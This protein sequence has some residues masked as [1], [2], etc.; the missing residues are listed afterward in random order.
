M[1][2][3]VRHCDAEDIERIIE[4]KCNTP[5]ESFFFRHTL[6][7]QKL[8]GLKWQRL[9]TYVARNDHLRRINVSQ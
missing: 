9:G 4:L 8:G 2:R 7:A 6:D 1:R 5:Q 3:S